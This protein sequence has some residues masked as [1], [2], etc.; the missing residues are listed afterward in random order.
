MTN[1]L[2]T[3]LDSLIGEVCRTMTGSLDL[4][5]GMD[6]LLEAEVGDEYSMPLHTDDLG[7]TFANIM[8][9][10]NLADLHREYISANLDHIDQAIWQ[11]A[12]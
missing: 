3:N 2:I 8:G 5:W 4:D 10:D 9:M 6:L 12:I 11:G 7:E 1:H